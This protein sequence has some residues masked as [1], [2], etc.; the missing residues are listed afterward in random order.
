[1][2]VD[3]YG[4]GCPVAFCFSNRVHETIFKLFFNQIKTKVGII[5]SKVFIS[6]DLPAL[7]NAWAVVVGPA[8]H[9]LLCTWHVDRNWRDNLSKISGGSEKKSLVYKT[10]RVFLQ[11]T[12]I[13]E[14]KVSLDQF[15]NDLLEDNDTAAYGTYFVQHYPKRS[16][17]WAYCYRLRLGINTNMYLESYHKVLKH[18]YL[19]GKKCKRIDKTINAVMKLAR[20]SM[21]KR[22]IK[23]AKNALNY[24]IRKIHESHKYSE[25]ISSDKILIA[26]DGQSWI[27][28]SLT[29][30]LENIVLP[31]LIRDAMNLV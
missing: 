25:S 15:I 27:I 5:K 14:F 2:T 11:M 16:E 4:T 7:Y 24:K 22:L 10:L 30:P 18:I 12:S 17:V 26:E 21:F 28:N 8:E 29:N 6:D 31:E 23:V 9:R 13:D 20:D 1:M 3:E 19:E